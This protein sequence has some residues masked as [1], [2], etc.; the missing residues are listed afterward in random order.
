ML[1]P[2]AGRPCYEQG[3]LLTFDPVWSL[4]SAWLCPLMTKQSN[5]WIIFHFGEW[6]VKPYAIERSKN[7]GKIVQ[8]LFFMSPSVSDTLMH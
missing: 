8:Q 1:C 5:Q 7:K 2:L 3:P 4:P 6:E